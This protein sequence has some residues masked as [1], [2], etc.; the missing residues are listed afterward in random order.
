MKGMLDLI[1]K[2]G[3]HA[4][5]NILRTLGYKVNADPLRADQLHHLFHLLKQY[6]WRCIKKHMGFIKEKD[7]FRLFCITCFRQCFKQLRH[8]KEQEG[9]IHG[10]TSNELLTIQDL[11][12]ATSRIVCTQPVPD[13]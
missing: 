9:G 10:R 2:L 13:I 7:H 3:K 11:D 1:A 12:P 6:P 5:R 8:H 4:I